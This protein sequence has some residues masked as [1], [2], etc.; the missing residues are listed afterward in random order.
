MTRVPR[1]IRWRDAKARFEEAT[2]LALGEPVALPSGRLAPLVAVTTR[3]DRTDAGEW[4]VSFRVETA[5]GMD[6]DLADFFR[7]AEVARALRDA[8]LPPPCPPSVARR[9]YHV[10]AP[11]RPAHRPRDRRRAAVARLV[12]A[13]AAW[14]FDRFGETRLLRPAELALLLGLIGV[15]N[16]ARGPRSRSGRFRGFYARMKRLVAKS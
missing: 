4:E 11:P 15:P 6:P 12:A 3:M 14:E 9:K 1:R 13:L 10:E 7:R 5:P 2:G 8:L 16:L